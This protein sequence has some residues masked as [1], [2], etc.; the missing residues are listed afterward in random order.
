MIH[1]NSEIASPPPFQPA[2]NAVVQP[3]C[4]AKTSSGRLLWR[5]RIL[6]R[7]P[8]WWW[9]FNFAVLITLAGWIVWAAQFTETW[10]HLEYEI[11]LLDDPSQLEQYARHFSLRGRIWALGAMV[12]AAVASGTLMLLGIALGNR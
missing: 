12:T 1:R 11:G 7:H 2:E 6:A 4:R 8:V 5:D 10:N 9:I 3:P